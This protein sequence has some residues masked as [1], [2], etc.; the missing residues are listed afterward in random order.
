[1]E[2]INPTPCERLGS[3]PRGSH[4]HLAVL[5]MAISIRLSI[6]CFLL[7]Q[8]AARYSFISTLGASYRYE[9]LGPTKVHR[10]EFGRSNLV[11]VK[12]GRTIVT[13]E[14]MK[15]LSAQTLDA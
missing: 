5:S 6:R 12:V 10:T 4:S 8:R 2:T 9:C 13:F 11:L 15:E 7:T 3:W 1:M 14:A